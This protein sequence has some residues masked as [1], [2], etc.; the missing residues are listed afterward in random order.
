M[1][2]EE[3][4]LE[5]LSRSKFGYITTEDGVAE[6]VDRLHEFFMVSRNLQAQGL[7]GPS[8]AAA[9]AKPKRNFS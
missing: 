8:A 5:N 4:V 1:A 3:I 9:A 2:L 7:H 6:L